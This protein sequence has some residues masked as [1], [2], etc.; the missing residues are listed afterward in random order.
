MAKLIL[1]IS[2]SK[3]LHSELLTELWS[4]FLS[5]NEFFAIFEVQV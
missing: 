3:A 4:W 2:D 1:G 5:Q